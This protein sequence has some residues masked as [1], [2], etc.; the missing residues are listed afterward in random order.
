[1]FESLAQKGRERRGRRWVLF[2]LGS[3]VVNAGWI[4]GAWFLI[5]TDAAPTDWEQVPITFA[6]RAE[7]PS[8]AEEAPASAPPPPP[9]PPPSASASRSVAGNQARIRRALEA[10]AAIPD[11]P[12]SETDVIR[13]PGSD[14]WSGKGDRE[15]GGEEGSRLEAEPQ[16]MA[17]PVA[18]GRGPVALDEPIEPP[19]PDPGNPLPE[20]PEEARKAGLEGLVEVR[21]AIAESG[22]VSAI[23]VVR[24]EEP[25]VAAVMARVPHWRFR[26]ARLDG[27]AVAVHRLVRVPFR[28]SR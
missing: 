27:E 5:P 10:P 24:G 14:Q 21:I 11:R 8:G 23:D 9:P 19:Q 16:P 17:A 6:A 13:P 28:L 7:S 1:M 4:L 25:F 2:V 3:V 18:A 20:Y 26:P 12:P 22:A 15:G